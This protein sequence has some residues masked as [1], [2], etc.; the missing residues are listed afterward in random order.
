MSIGPAT[1]TGAPTTALSSASICPRWRD[2]SMNSGATSAAVSATTSKTA[3][4]V[5]KW[6]T[7]AKSTE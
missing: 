6:R 7:S 1:T 2:Q 3:T 4:N 5:R